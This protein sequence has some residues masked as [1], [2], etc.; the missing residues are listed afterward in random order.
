MLTGH[1][2]DGEVLLTQDR[3]GLINHGYSAIL[4]NDPGFFIIDRSFPILGA[5]PNIGSA[6]GV[7]NLTLKSTGASLISLCHH[8]PGASAATPSSIIAGQWNSTLA[9]T[10]EYPGGLLTAMGSV[11]RVKSLMATVRRN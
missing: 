7:T 1:Y 3:I 9:P 10:A 2:S 6:D 11:P 5:T 4:K 8:R